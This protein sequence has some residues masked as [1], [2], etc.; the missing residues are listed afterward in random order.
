MPVPIPF[1]PSNVWRRDDAKRKLRPSAEALAAAREDVAV[2]RPFRFMLS[3]I[4][5][6]DDTLRGVDCSYQDAKFSDAPFAA[7][8]E[9]QRED[10]ERM[11]DEDYA[12]SIASAR[13]SVL[14]FGRREDGP[15][16]C[17]RADGFRPWFRVEV[18]DEWTDTD[19]RRFVFALA[20][21]LCLPTTSDAGDAAITFSVERRKRFYGWVPD[22]R[23]PW[24]TRRFVYLR[25][26]FASLR[27]L[28]AAMRKI[29]ASALA[30]KTTRWTL[31]KLPDDFDVASFK[32]T[33]V[34]AYAKW[35]GAAKERALEMYLHAHG[36]IPLR[37]ADHL[38]SATSKFCNDLG[39]GPSEWVSVACFGPTLSSQGLSSISNCDIEVAVK[40]D[41]S[42]LFSAYDDVALASRPVRDPV[43]GPVSVSVVSTPGPTLV[44]TPAL[45][46]WAAALGPGEFASSPL[47]MSKRVREWRA[48]H[49]TLPETV[50][51][52]LLESSLRSNGALVFETLLA[53]KPSPLAII[54][55]LVIASFD[56][57]MYSDDDTF[58]DVIRGH[59]TKYIGTN[60]R[61]GGP[62]GPLVRVMQCVGAVSKPDP[63]PD[64]DSSAEDVEIHVECYNTERE[65]YEAWRDLIVSV[66][67]DILVSWNGFGFDFPFMH[68]DYMQTFASGAE[69]FT[70]GMQHAMRA[71]ARA[72]LASSVPPVPPV[73]PVSPVFP[74]ASVSS[75]SVSTPA[76]TPASFAL[77][78]STVSAAA[79]V[80]CPELLMRLRA[81]LQ[82]A[83]PTGW[84]EM[85]ALLKTWSRIYG[86]KFVKALVAA[87]KVVK[88]V[89]TSIAAR[90]R[91]SSVM[92]VDTSADMFSIFSAALI[93]NASGELDQTQNKT[94]AEDKEGKEDSD[95]EDD[96]GD[97]DDDN[98]EDENKS[99][100]SNR[101][102]DDYED[103]AFA[104]ASISASASA[105]KAQ[106]NLPQDTTTAVLVKLSSLPAADANKLRLEL[107]DRLR[108]AVT[109][110]TQRLN[111]IHKQPT[112]HVVVAE[113]ELSAL[114]THDPFEL[115]LLLDQLALRPS[116]FALAHPYTDPLLPS[117]P[118][119]ASASVPSVPSMLSSPPIQR[120][121]RDDFFDW[122][123]SQKCLGAGVVR[124]LVQSTL[125]ASSSHSKS[126]LLPAPRRGL[127]LSRLS[128]ERCELTEKRMNSAAKGD[129]VYNFY[130]M[131]GRTPAD[132]MQ[133]VKVGFCIC[134]SLCLSVSVFVCVCVCVCVCRVCL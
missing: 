39:V 71:R 131:A 89:D 68:A 128:A 43:R 37:I 62:S 84:R 28:Q 129:N 100:D 101:D 119:M 45:E 126:T 38:Q 104:S 74:A 5:V 112:R 70:E 99:Q 18:P 76:L 132:L 53:W 111:A 11:K 24:V 51:R 9:E 125:N 44:A 90:E 60:F 16:V 42:S 95:G 34:Q 17:V 49:V 105:S 88:A 32:N 14:L 122:V 15:T 130:R 59:S 94:S 106:R 66:D 109:A 103:H 29:K 21:S 61:V 83:N 110:A 117:L 93:A 4:R 67:P 65:C 73:S 33:S 79:A 27:A 113:A 46:A 30:N 86:G 25:L 85:R 6:T 98:E 72:M 97:N 120:S 102:R 7:V 77:S 81:L 1:H 87:E 124:L 116:M 115:P 134:V 54:A 118:L 3:D 63:T 20:K 114:A 82:T 91:M 10:E 57:E 40:A 47:H 8:L 80:S 123:A 92:H 52:S 26:A 96:D 108:D 48:A 13:A 75:A 69:C 127:F 2:R 64:R 78:A 35:S 41:A 121:A 133:I 36:Q 50:R 58:P 107:R 19:H 23:R 12:T 31:T 56:C 22:R 55:P